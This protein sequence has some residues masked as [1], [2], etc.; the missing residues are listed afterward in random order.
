MKRLF[1][2]LA[3]CAVVSFTSCSKEKDCACTTTEPLTGLETTTTI[4]IEEGKCSDLDTNV[5][6]LTT[7]CVRE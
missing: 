3:V 4:T 6:G 7:T 1:V 5:A 2:L